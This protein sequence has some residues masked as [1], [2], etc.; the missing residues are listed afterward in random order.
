MTRGVA[1]RRW[2]FGMGSSSAAHVIGGGRSPGTAA[3]GRTA[4]VGEAG[5]MT[6]GP[7]ATVPG[8]GGLI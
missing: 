5:P 3:A 2:G 7:E 6:R 8:W 1:G 4:R